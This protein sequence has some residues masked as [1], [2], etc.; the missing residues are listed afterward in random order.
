MY[1]FVFSEPVSYTH[2]DVYKRQAQHRCRDACDDILLFHIFHFHNLLVCCKSALLRTDRLYA[3]LHLSLIHIY[4]T[5][6]FFFIHLPPY[7]YYYFS[8]FDLWFTIINYML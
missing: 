3:D 1:L 4:T 5:A 2:L 7:R 8:P 6:A